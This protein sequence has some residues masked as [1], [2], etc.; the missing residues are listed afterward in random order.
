MKPLII[1]GISGQNDDPSFM[2]K[3]IAKLTGKKS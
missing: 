3:I 2:K 1:K